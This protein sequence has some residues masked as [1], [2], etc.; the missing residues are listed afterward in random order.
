MS[1]SKQRNWDNIQCS[2]VVT[3]LVPVLN[4][5]RLACF[6]AAWRLESGA[7]LN[8]IP[9]NRVGTFI[10]DDTLRI[11]V[12]LRVFLTVCIPHR[13]KCG[14]TV[15]AF[16]TL[17]LSCR[18]GAGR[19]LRH[20][21]LSDV[22]RRDLSAAGMP[23]MLEP[24]GPD[25][26]DRKRSD[27]ITV[28]PYSR[29]RCLIWDATCVN[30]FAYSNLIRAALAAGY[31][32]DAAEVRKVAKYAELIRHF[33]FQPVAVETSGAMGKSTMQFF[34]DFGRRL[35]VRFQDQRE[36]DFLFQSVF[37]YSQRERLQHFAV[38]L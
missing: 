36:S 19:I 1:A 17:P 31:V 23:S 26:A 32:A 37:G 2:S 13:S 3:T 30:T 35:A 21:S 33:I 5:H 38:L 15:G 25:R 22:V 27:A 24:S 34:N 11:S 28:Y 20:S 6:M 10:D 12:A 8:C 18:F 29:G 4:L 16:G 14:T 9:N 7:W